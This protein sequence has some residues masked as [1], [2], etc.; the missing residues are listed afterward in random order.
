MEAHNLQ[1][2]LLATAPV[3]SARNG[4]EAVQAATKACELAGWKSPVYLDTLAAAYAEAGD[5]R[6]AIKW[7][8]KTLADPAW[9]RLLVQWGKRQLAT[10]SSSIARVGRF[11]MLPHARRDSIHANAAGSFRP[12]SCQE[13]PGS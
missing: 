10:G 1:A 11:G 13:T 9:L 3:P 8:E 4:T 2:R 5:F 12:S 7:Q 6:E